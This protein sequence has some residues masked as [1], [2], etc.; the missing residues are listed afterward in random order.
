MWIFRYIRELGRWAFTRWRLHQAIV[1]VL[2]ILVGLVGLTRLDPQPRVIGGYLLV[3]LAFLTLVV[4]PARLWHTQGE[5]LQ[6][7]VTFIDHED[8][9]AIDPDTG[10]QFVRVTVKNRSASLLT[11]V[12][13][14]LA[15]IEPRP[16]Q[17]MTLHVPL[18]PM[19]APP[20]QSS[21][22]LQPETHRT[23]NLLSLDINAPHACIWH[24]VNAVPR[25][26]PLGNYRIKLIVSTNETPPTE[27]WLRVE[28]SRGENSQTLSIDRE[29]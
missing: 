12:E 11:G 10:L 13:V 16:S 7:G 24:V 15:S 21:F 22:P 25:T 14:V 6:P 8:D 28:V 29:A 4:A 5:R 1:G 23:V 19:H 3:W 20:E 17:F 18:Q 2:L 9:A 27:Q 26:L